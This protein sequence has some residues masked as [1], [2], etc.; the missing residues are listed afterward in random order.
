MRVANELGAGNGEGAKFATMVSVITSTVIGFVFW[1]VIMI[2][3]DK[4]VL[5]FTSSE[6]VLEVVDKLKVLLAFTI[7]LNSVQPVLSGTLFFLA[8]LVNIWILIINKSSTNLVGISHRDFKNTKATFSCRSG[9][10][11][12]MAIICGIHKSGLLLLD[13]PTTWISLWM[14]IPPRSYG[15]C[16]LFLLNLRP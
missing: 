2:F 8:F 9:C 13:R 1:L 4:I 15:T 14:G 11:V 7:L 5:L 12:R 10:G 3:N 16:C 6:P